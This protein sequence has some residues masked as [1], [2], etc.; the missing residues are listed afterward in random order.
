RT[1]VVREFPSN[2]NTKSIV[3]LA[4]EIQAG[5][6]KQLFIFGGDPVYNVPR[7]LA[8]DSETKVPTD[9]ADLQ[10]KVPGIVRLGYH[11]DATSSLSEWHVPAAHFLESWGD[12]RSSDGV[13][14][15]IQPMILPLFGGLSEIELMNM[16]MGGPKVEGAELVQETFR[17]SNPPGDFGTAWSGFLRDGFATHI[18]LRDRPPSFNGSASAAIAR[19]SWAPTPAPVTESP[20]IV[21]VRSYAIDDGRF[22]NNGWLQEL[23]D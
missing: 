8:Q 23:P 7:G 16:L 1:V 5:R 13:Y 14:L 20:E 12:A 9:W 19:Q 17:T 18:P 10:K 2:P 21:F 3:H 11:E 15:S 6:V 22:I 4:E